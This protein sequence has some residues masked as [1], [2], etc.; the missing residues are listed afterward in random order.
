MKIPI[1]FTV[2]AL[3]AA[4]SGLHSQPPKTAGEAFKN[5][6]VLKRVPADQWF[7]TMA[8]IAGSLGVTCDHC[9]SSKF[10]TDEGNPAKLK[11][12]EMMRMVDA[13]NA[14]HFGG[15]KV[16]TCNS[17]H[18][19][20]LKPQGA[21]VPNAEHWMKAA[22]TAPPLPPADEILSRYRK[23]ITTVRTQSLSLRIERYGGKGPALLASAEVLLD[24][25]KARITNHE[26]NILT[27]MIR[28]GENAWIDEGKGW[29]MMNR[30][31]TFDAFEVA[32][33]LAPDQVG[34]VESTGAVFEDSSGGLRS[35]VV[36]A[37]TKDGK[38][39]FFF[40]ETS[41]A[42]LRQRLFFSSFY[43]DGS[44]DINYA[45][46]KNFGD[47]RL[48]TAI[49]VVNAGGPGLIVRRVISRRV[50]IRLATTDFQV[51]GA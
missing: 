8:F 37:A 27:T 49:Q 50:N 15:Q 11:A 44:V 23:S 29:R 25:N 26:G 47:A 32:E 13:I 9:H 39:W 46:Y 45:D 22:E 21:P 18:R 41:G 34:E 48:P 36:P 10:E 24:G 2:S 7:D 5:I 12:R 17:C 43:G 33:V 20:T 1:V 30:G 19:G 3:F 51:P 4:T 6:Q 31:E 14:E 40:D 38:K 28:N 35:F 16:V 42:L